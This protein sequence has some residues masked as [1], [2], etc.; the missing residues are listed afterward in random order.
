MVAPRLVPPPLA[1]VLLGEPHGAAGV[2]A[3]LLDAVRRGWI[4][5][6]SA[7]V[8]P[9]MHVRKRAAASDTCG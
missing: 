1:A 6:Q 8:L 5:V 9:S 4:S 3:P 2:S 7:M